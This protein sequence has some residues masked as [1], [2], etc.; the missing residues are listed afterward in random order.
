MLAFEQMLC[1]CEIVSLNSLF[2][3]RVNGHFSIK[4]G[5]E[6]LVESGVDHFFPLVVN[7]KGVGGTDCYR[8]TKQSG[9]Q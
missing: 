9:K 3:V 8:H 5:L 1:M 7:E 2:Q 4:I 6:E